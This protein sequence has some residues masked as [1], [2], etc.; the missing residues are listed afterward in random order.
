M[1]STTSMKTFMGHLFQLEAFIS[2]LDYQKDDDQLSMKATRYERM[3]SGLGG[4]VKIV[5]VKKNFD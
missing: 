2:S 5:P 4:D 1:I 3:V